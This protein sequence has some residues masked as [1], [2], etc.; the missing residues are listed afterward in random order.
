VGRKLAKKIYSIELTTTATLVKTQ[1]LSS[2]G[3]IQPYKEYV[4]EWNMGV[5][6]NLV[7]VQEGD[8]HID[9]V[10]GTAKNPFSGVEYTSE[11]ETV[12]VEFVEPVL[13]KTPSQTSQQENDRPIR[14]QKPVSRL[15]PSFEGKSYGTTMAQISARMVCLSETES[16]KF[17]ESELTRMGTDGN[18]HGPHVSKTSYKEVWRRLDN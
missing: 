3:V 18:Y 6:E 1:T 14:T 4:D 16:I 2:T 12:D 9:Q 10:M 7:E 15:I 5:P 11:F 13:D 8:G 17:M